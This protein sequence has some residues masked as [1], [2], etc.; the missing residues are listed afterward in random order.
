MQQPS[1]GHLIVECIDNLPYGTDNLGRE[2]TINSEDGGKNFLYV[3]ADI[4]EDGAGAPDG[5]SPDINQK[6]REL[7][8]GIEPMTPVLPRLCATTAPHEP[9]IPYSV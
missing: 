9:A 2:E 4:H 1:P 6:P 8:M 3:D 5:S 7:V